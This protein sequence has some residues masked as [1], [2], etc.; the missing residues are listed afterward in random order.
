MVTFGDKTTTITN[1]RKQIARQTLAR[2]ALEPRGT[3]KS[4][5]NIILDGTINNNTPTTITLDTNTRTKMVIRKNY[6]AIVNESKPRLM[7][8]VACKT[9]REY[10]RNQGKKQFLFKEKRQA[11]Q[12][13]QKQSLQLKRPESTDIASGLKDPN[14]PG[15]SHQQDIPGP[16]KRKPQQRKQKQQPT[17]LPQKPTS[18]FDRK[19][20]EAAIAQTKLNKAKERQRQ[21]S[22]SPRVQLDT[23]QLHANQ[24]IEVINL[25]SD[26]SQGSPENRQDHHPHNPFTN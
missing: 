21:L 6:L 25:A 4:Q 14:E 26:S 19:S 15:P 17:K 10:N 7:Q 12:V 9:V 24:S 11:K 13:Q 16:S 5:W 2:K 20:K 1:T 23:A 8:F 18:D 22:Q 3:L